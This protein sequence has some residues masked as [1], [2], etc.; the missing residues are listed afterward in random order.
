MK[1]LTGIVLLLVSQ[2]CAQI[3]ERS[4]H[5]LPSFINESSG[6]ESCGDG[7]LITV[8]DSGGEPVLYLISQEGEFLDTIRIPNATNRDWEDLA[9]NE[10]GDLFIGDIGNN[11]NQ[12]KDLIIYKVPDFCQK[13]VRVVQRITFNYEDQQA[14]PPDPS[15]Q[16]FDAEGLIATNDSLFIFT[17]NRTQ[18]F[19][20][21]LRYYSLANKTG[22]HT[23]KLRG[24]IRLKGGMK[25]NWI[26]AADISNDGKTILLLSMGKITQLN[27]FSG[28]DFLEGTLTE[29]SLPGF[30][31]KEALWIGKGGNLFVTDEQTLLLGRK[32]YHFQLEKAD[33]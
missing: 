28:T 26:T 23:A 18:P 29:L 5:S 27:E 14:F 25:K 3:R 7:K 16:Y 33:E 6:L 19:D 12:R 15:N 8:N 24:K 1:I 22:D 17:K 21:E 32:L 10:Q 31:Q 30:S 9:I 4:V 11:L 20:G 13:G 2:A